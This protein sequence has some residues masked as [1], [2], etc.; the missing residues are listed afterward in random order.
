MAETYNAVKSLAIPMKPAEKSFK[1][2]VD[3]LKEHQIPEPNK[4][5]ERFKL[6]RG[7]GKRGIAI[8]ILSRIISKS[9]IGLMWLSVQWKSRWKLI[10]E[11]QL[12]L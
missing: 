1:E 12:V 6:I 11:H 5:T 7:T 3:L 8:R 4:I 9:C 10:Q 2:I